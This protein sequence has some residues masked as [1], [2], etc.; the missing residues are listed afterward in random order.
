MVTP[1]YPFFSLH[2]WAAAGPGGMSGAWLA[3]GNRG[4]G[5][6]P[7]AGWLPDGRPSAC[8]GHLAG[9]PGARCTLGRPACG[10]DAW[11]GP[12]AALLLGPDPAASTLAGAWETTPPP[13]PGVRPEALV[14]VHAAQLLGELVLGH[15]GLLPA[16]MRPGRQRVSPR[17]QARQGAWAGSRESEFRWVLAMKAGAAPAG[18]QCPGRAPGRSPASCRA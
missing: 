10:A 16:G 2:R 17:T 6:G 8:A 18:T 4:A 3:D 12:W 11:L 1:L 14:A 13:L 9:G 15:L 5:A 7:A